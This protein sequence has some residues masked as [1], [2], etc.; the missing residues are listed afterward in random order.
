MISIVTVN[1]N[2]SDF[3]KL[4]LN[5]LQKLTL[6]PH[7]VIIADN[8]SKTNDY[9]RLKQFVQPY[10]NIQTYKSSFKLR[11]SLA[12]GAALNELISKVTTPYCLIT[13]SD[14]APIQKEWD[15]FLIKSL[16]FTNSSLIGSATPEWSH[17]PKDFP[18]PFFLF[19]K[20]NDI[21]NLII[22][23]RPQNIELDQD[24]GW[25]LREKLIAQQI[26]FQQLATKNDIAFVR[27][28]LFYLA[29]QPIA[30]HFGRGASLGGLKYK[31]GNLP[32]ISK[33][34]RLYLGKKEKKKWLDYYSA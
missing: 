27:S 25:Q 29:D 30:A 13:D 20:T 32:L 5:N 15:Q 34:Y 2:T 7:Q 12:H 22:D 11:G 21:K 1:Y 4:L 17:K 23:F 19:F 3:I 14:C 28:D 24:T 16:N 6:N 18:A 10:P 31:T 8:W 33:F 9:H 26:P